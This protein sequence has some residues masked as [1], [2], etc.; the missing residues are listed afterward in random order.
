MCLAVPMKVLKVEGEKAR[1]ALSGLEQEVDVRFLEG[2]KPGEYVI[3]HAGFAIEKLDAAE[4]EE[5]LALFKEIDE[6]GG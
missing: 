1:V 6:A 3:V 4:A 2:L 5:T